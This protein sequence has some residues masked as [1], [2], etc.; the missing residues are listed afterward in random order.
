MVLQAEQ[1]CIDGLERREMYMKWIKLLCE[2]SVNGLER[3][4]LNNNACFE[5]ST[6]S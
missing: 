4:Q 1:I 5:V 6:W 2:A 3:R